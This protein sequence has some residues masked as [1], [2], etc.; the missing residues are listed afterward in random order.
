MINKCE[1]C[2]SP[3]RVYDSRDTSSSHRRR[4]ACKC[5]NRWTTWERREQRPV[6]DS[7]AGRWVTL[8]GVTTFLPVVAADEV[9]RLRSDEKVRT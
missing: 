8:K 4:Y 9:E 2:G 3:G 6:P 5:G 1:A 7:I